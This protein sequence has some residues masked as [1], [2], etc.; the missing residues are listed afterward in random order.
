MFYP[1]VLHQAE[2]RFIGSFYFDKIIASLAHSTDS[3]KLTKDTL[4]GTTVSNLKYLLE[5]NAPRICTC[6]DRFNQVPATKHLRTRSN[7]PGITSLVSF[8]AQ[9]WHCVLFMLV[10]VSQPWFVI[11]SIMTHCIENRE[12]G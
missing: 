9:N 7:V 4:Q 12:S 5:G 2:L 6:T 11:L 3:L 10:S 1:G 8:T